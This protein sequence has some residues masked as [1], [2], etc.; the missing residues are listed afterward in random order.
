MLI[1]GFLKIFVPLGVGSLTG[2]AVGTLVGTLLG[3]GTHHTFYFICRADHGRRR[4][5]GRD[6][7]VDRLLTILSCRR[8][9]S[10]RRAAAGDAWQPDREGLR[11]H[12]QLVG[13][14]FPHLTGEGRLQLLALHDELGD[15][16]EEVWGGAA[17]RNDRRGG[18]RHRGH[19]LSF[20]AYLGQQACSI[21]SG[22]GLIMLD[23][24]RLEAVGARCRRGCS[25]ARLRST[26]SS[27]PR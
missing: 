1:A 21:F 15:L 14:R 23:R 16:R 8:A 3:L 25:K 19:V 11:R 6:P 24:G 22:T 13:K 2:A 10:S 12:A 5:R 18:Q 26:G 27:R 7:F 17:G 20:S 9:R 4:R